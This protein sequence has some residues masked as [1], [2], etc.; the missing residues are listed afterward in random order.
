MSETAWTA[1]LVVRLRRLNA[2]VLNVHGHDMQAPGWPDLYVAHR[3]WSGWLEVKTA[4]GRL[5]KVQQLVIDGLRARNVPA[6]VLRAGDPMEL[7]NHEGEFLGEA[8]DER[9]LLSLL[10]ELEN[11][12]GN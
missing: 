12:R 5:R 3:R 2:Q 8:R 6:F 7:E 9:E 1:K 10:E 11:T 4:K